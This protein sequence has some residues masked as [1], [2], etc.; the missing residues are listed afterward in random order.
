MK[1]YPRDRVDMVNHDFSAE[2][3]DLSG[4]GG[5]DT[6][7]RASYPSLFCGELFGLLKMSGV[8]VG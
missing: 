5:I 2:A 4:D 1:N 6:E 7:L 3:A 8:T